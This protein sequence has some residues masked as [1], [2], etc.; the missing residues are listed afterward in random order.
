MRIELGNLGVDSMKTDVPKKLVDDIEK[1]RER[2]HQRKPRVYAK[3]MKYLQAEKEGRQTR[4]S[5]LDFAFNFDCNFRCPHCCAKVFRGLPTQASMLVGDMKH[6][7]DQADEL[8]IF[9]FSLIGGEPLVWAEFD[10]IV[11][12]VDSRRFHI[13]VTTNGW[14][15]NPS[16]AEHLISIGVDKVGVSIDSGFEDEHDG[17]R[18]QPGGFSRAI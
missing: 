5:L 1:S 13:S 14:M 11:E 6:I 12:A 18:S 17:F 16:T 4:M 2:L 7:A 15:L 9:I 10:K 8:G 3:L